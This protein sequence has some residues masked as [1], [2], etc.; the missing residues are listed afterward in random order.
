MELKEALSVLEKQA[1]YAQSMVS[2]S[3]AHQKAEEDVLLW[4]TEQKRFQL[5]VDVLREKVGLPDLIAF[6]QYQAQLSDEMAMWCSEHNAPGY[7]A[8][9]YAKERDAYRVVLTALEE[10]MKWDT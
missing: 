8:R 2:W 9:D 4:E 3:I 1:Q 10:R 6:F 5:A 7:M